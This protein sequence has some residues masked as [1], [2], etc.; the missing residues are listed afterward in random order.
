M[1]TRVRIRTNKKNKGTKNI[2]RAKITTEIPE[3]KTEKLNEHWEIKQ[4]QKQKKLFVERA[5][6]IFFVFLF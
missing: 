6:E 2:T 1:N 4:K 5:L 3:N